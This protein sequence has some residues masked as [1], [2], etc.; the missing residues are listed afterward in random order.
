MDN[1]KNFIKIPLKL[2]TA[3]LTYGFSSTQLLVVLYVIRK[4]YGWNKKKD[5]I[6]I[7]KI[8][9]DTGKR[10]QLI[11]R[12]VSELKKMSV[13]GVERKNSNARPKMWVEEPENWFKSETVEFHETVGFHVT[14]SCIKC[15]RTV[16]PDET[17][18][19]HQSETVEFHTIDNI[20]PNKKNYLIEEP[21]DSQ[22]GEDEWLDPDE[23]WRRWREQNG[24]V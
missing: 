8:A 2:Y 14:K 19:F 9:S 16:S 20:E 24:A 18:E 3:V 6:A 1:S 17:V 4:T 22:K 13:L 7:S 15:N 21:S 5:V 23:A 10:R 11:S 12:T